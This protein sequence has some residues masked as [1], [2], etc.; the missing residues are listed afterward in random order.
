MTRRFLM[1]LLATFAA[2][3]VLAT[4]APVNPASAQ[5]D[6]ALNEIVKR[7]KLR[8][9]WAVWFPYAYRDSDT[10]ELSGFSI[11]LGNELGKVLGVEVE[12][13]EDSWATLIAGL[14]ARKFDMNLPMGI[15][16]KRA[17]AVTYTAPFIQYNEGLMVPK[18]EAGK[19]NHWRELDVGGMRITATLGS[20]T[21]GFL[22]KAL[23]NAELIRAKDGAT[24][25]AQVLTGR[26]DAWAN[27][28][29]A[30][31]KILMERDDLVVVPGPV[32]AAVPVAFVVRQGDYHFREWINYFI[33]DEVQ[34]GALDR[35]AEKHGL[36]GLVTIMEP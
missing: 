25:V 13:V 35:L 2:I 9:G 36:A 12:W 11:D 24:S 20:T 27:G 21:D 15:T 5:T 14:Q 29:G 33:R 17:V 8:I 10:K 22:T 4:T 19:Y 30:F 18:T 28:Y 7:G 16:L 32:M 34:T 26:A 3:A 1:T 6:S 31:E 23:V